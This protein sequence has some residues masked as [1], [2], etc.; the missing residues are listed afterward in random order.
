MNAETPDDEKSPGAAPYDLPGKVIGLA[1]RVHRTLGPGFL[2]TVYRNALCIEL[3]DAALE[4]EIERDL[5]LQYRDHVVARSR[6]D[7]ITRC[8]LLIEIKAVQGLLPTH[9]VQPVND[10]TA[11]GIETGL[12]LD[13]G[14]S[15]LQFKRR[16]RTFP[17]QS[18]PDL[19][20]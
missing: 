16:T 4:F 20:P 7:L 2:E 15:F 18:P 1:L 6:A 12:H 10:L 9:E 14:N 13:F 8:E 19:H 11:I 3:A 17:G 5:T